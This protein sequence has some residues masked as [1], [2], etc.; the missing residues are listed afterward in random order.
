M[1]DR[2]SCSFSFFDSLESVLK[3]LQHPRWRQHQ[4]CG[5]HPAK[6]HLAHLPLLLALLPL[7]LALPPLLPPPLFHITNS[8]HLPATKAGGALLERL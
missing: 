7:L 1:C 4:H 6:K 3:R 8:H 2:I 5:L